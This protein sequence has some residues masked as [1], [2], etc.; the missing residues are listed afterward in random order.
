MGI[1]N[2]T[3]NSDYLTGAES[4]DIINGLSGNDT[5]FGY[6]GNDSLSGGP[7]NDSLNGGPGNDTLDGGEGND[8]L[9]GI[10]SKTL[11][12]GGAGDDMLIGDGDQSTMFGGLGNDS[13]RAW[14]A[15]GT[16]YGEDGNDTIDSSGMAW[17]GAGNDLLR[18]EL[19]YD[20]RA[21]LIGGSGDDRYWVA[22]SL[23]SQSTLVDPL[24]DGADARN[25]REV[26]DIE[27]PDADGLILSRQGA[28]LVVFSRDSVDALVR[29]QGNFYTNAATGLEE[30]AIDE[31]NIKRYGS[32]IASL[33]SAEIFR[34][35]SLD[36]T[37]FGDDADTVLGDGFA[38]TLRGGAGND[39]LKGFGG[40]DV[41]I[42][43]TG[44][45]IMY[46]GL[47]SNKYYVDNV[48]D[49]VISSGRGVDHVFTNLDTYALNYGV[50]NL[51]MGGKQGASPDEQQLFAGKGGVRHGIGN[52]LDNLM[53]GGEGAELFE[54]GNDGDTLQGGGGNDTLVGDWLE[55]KDRDD[56]ADLLQGGAGDDT[57]VLNAGVL[58]YSN[59]RDSTG[60]YQYTDT[61][62]EEA[63]QGNDT[64]ETNIEGY[65]AGANIENVISTAQSV[66][67]NGLNNWLQGNAEA[68]GL[69]GAAGDDT[70]QGGG[71]ND[72]YEGGAGNDL[73][74]ADVASSKDTFFWGRGDGADVL[75]DAGGA[76]RLE[77]TQGVKAEQLWL[78][79]VGDDLQLSVVGTLDA[80][81][82]EGWYLSAE[83]Q[84]EFIVL[85]DGRALDAPAVE[86]LVK[87]MAPLTPPPLG[88]NDLPPDV[89]AQLSP[90]LDQAWL[91]GRDTSA[92]PSYL[93]PRLAGPVNAVF[94]TLGLGSEVADSMS[95][96]NQ[97][98]ALYGYAGDDT[99]R[100]T[101]EADTLFG[102]EG[103]DLLAGGDGKDSLEG[104]GGAD[105][106]YGGAGDDLLSGGSGNDSLF[107]LGANTW[108][109]LPQGLDTLLGGA[110]DDTLW[111]LDGS[112]LDGGAG[113]DVYNTYDAAQGDGPTYLFGVGSGQD[114]VTGRYG[115]VLMGA[116]IRAEDVQVLVNTTL[117][118]SGYS[119][120]A[121]YSLV[122]S[123][124]QAADQLTLAAEWSPGLNENKN[125][126]IVQFADGTIKTWAQLA[127]L[128]R[129]DDQGNLL[130]L[131]SATGGRLSG[132]GGDDTMYGSDG[133]DTLN[134]DAGKDAMYGGS[135]NDILSGG[136]GNDAMFGDDGN[137]TLNGDA[138]DDYLVGGAGNNVLFGGQGNDRLYGEGVNSGRKDSSTLLGGE[139]NDDLQ[140][141]FGSDLLQ[142]DEG[143]DTLNGGG[144]NSD[145]LIGGAGSDTYEFDIWRYR[146]EAS[147]TI[148]DASSP[149]GQSDS[150]LETLRLGDL[151]FDEVTLS[152]EGVDL[153]VAKRRPSGSS[154]DLVQVRVKG[155]FETDPASGSFA[156]ALDR[157]DFSDG[158]TID[159][160]F[161]Q[162][163]LSGQTPVG[164][165][166]DD[167]LIGTAASEFIVGQA[168]N[169]TLVA[170]DG[171]DTLF[172]GT[173][174]DL[175]QGGYGNDVYYVDSPN[176]R[177]V[178][179][180]SYGSITEYGVIDTV[181]TN[182][183]T[184]VLPADVENLVLG[185]TTWPA[186]VVWDATNSPTDG[187]RK[188]F[189]NALANTMTGGEGSEWLV[190]GT[191]DVLI[192]GGG[193]DT[194][195][196]AGGTPA[197]MEGGADDDV[198]LGITGSE[199]LIIEAPDGGYDVQY[200]GSYLA[201]QVEALYSNAR[202]LSGNAGNNL[203]VS[204]S[205]TASSLQGLSGNDTLQGAGKG[206]TYEGG[207]GDDL[208]I[209]ASTTS[210]DQYQWGRGM[211][212]DVLRDAGGAD[213][214]L[215][216]NEEVTRDQLWL[217]RVGQDL[218]LSV[219]GTSDRF[220]IEG[221]YD[222]ADHQIETLYL[223]SA[224][225]Y[226]LDAS[227][228]QRVVDAMAA[229]TP[230]PVGQTTLSP[231]VL[232]Q[233]APVLAQA[234][235]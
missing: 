66:Q 70:L 164:T 47:G 133:A 105:E 169:D 99:L 193:K 188:A 41:L 89:L 172:G 39:V 57:Y 100:G 129:A 198:Y 131:S 208:L 71:G 69:A 137:D 152:R 223:F 73:L 117:L 24:A 110:G 56:Y 79:R 199:T 40:D 143:D 204:T 33:D 162:Q 201:Y 97:A 78:S 219:V 5:L 74:L 25:E 72:D 145:T 231:E 235:F 154:D 10:Y 85:S 43:G 37:L 135:G 50:Q 60:T 13:L 171:D 1:I 147:E 196:G 144:G 203:I 54:G 11:L 36:S 174:A 217:Q 183:L 149:I 163:L 61:I 92:V 232:A 44:A 58:V 230:P 185:E 6:N 148:I 170:V 90:A 127:G 212:V 173:G 120:S 115:T 132:L 130:A 166:G 49:L 153:V 84:V 106:L 15:G 194:L 30:S 234:W 31:L 168:G 179:T 141:D 180:L 80:F 155:Q 32:V 216:I 125:N 19:S 109:T 82:V 233:L 86:A 77:V 94:T 8:T 220:T 65:V 176:D 139:G 17:G 221:W 211:G 68:T 23:F 207:Q 226:R 98:V 108:G 104:G 123:L 102:G 42:G 186:D 159:S 165:A 192:G 87:A 213:E 210:S 16:S 122:L 209:S 161:I 53:T 113:A 229:F 29:V 88:Q 157:I 35:L 18:V 75:R 93:A 52:D 202:A 138:G 151:R 64:V 26:L 146:S 34:R 67:G 114:T 124:P 175:M 227:G 218:S 195:E 160:A 118:T 9:N 28:D 205:S 7:G 214:Y 101:L 142:G 22:E 178:D 55:G 158:Y 224:G 197:R 112:T 62:V 119:F 51:T 63:D 81:T 14:S 177:V 111:G 83:H 189:G 95:G 46:G 59:A 187:V 156:N 91:A 140:C 134:G 225:R 228:V 96:S 150:E 48:N 126:L 38:D 27:Q 21:T 184:Y 206:D 20:A 167:Q 107:A 181:H 136:L 215:F 12:M 200:G 2:G 116:G 128:D 45:D 222:G 121:D 103:R 3:P 182:L 4:D 76:D 190:G 191:G